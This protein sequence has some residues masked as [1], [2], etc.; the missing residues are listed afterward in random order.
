M[1]W[2]NIVSLWSLSAMF[3]VVLADEP[4]VRNSEKSGT[5][6]IEEDEWVH[7]SEEPGRHVD[8]AREAF[9]EVDARKAAAE[10]RKA[11]A[12]LRVSARMPPNG[13]KPP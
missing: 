1:R 10:L 13:Q 7:L 2:L 8:H 3:G 11:A 9:V 5:I 12:Y 6:W 4:K